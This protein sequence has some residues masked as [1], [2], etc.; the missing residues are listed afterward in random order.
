M[1]RWLTRAQVVTL[2]ERNFSAH[3]GAEQTW[4]VK[5]YAPWCGHCKRLVPV[6]RELAERLRGRGFHSHN[7]I[8]MEFVDLR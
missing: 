2:T 7:G 5:F 3:V 6:W 1:W 8:W 4:F